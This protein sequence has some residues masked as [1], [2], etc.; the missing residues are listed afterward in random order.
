MAEVAAVAGIKEA[1]DALIGINELALFILIR[2]KDGVQVSDAIA[3]WDKIS[4]DPDFMAKMHAAYS[5]A[6]LVPDELV[7][8]TAMEDFELASIQASYLTKF[9]AAL[10]A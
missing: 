10:K 2:L 9:I 7:H 1:K 8:A 5:G 3:I 6:C 4:K